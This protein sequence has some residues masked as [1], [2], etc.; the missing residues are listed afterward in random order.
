MKICERNQENAR[1]IRLTKETLVTIEFTVRRSEARTARYHRGRNI[2]PTSAIGNLIFL[3]T[4]KLNIAS[5]LL[6]Y[7]QVVV[8][9]G[10]D[11]RAEAWN[12]SRVSVG[13]DR[14]IRRKEGGGR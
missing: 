12:D 2:N 11:G 5:L 9:S 6:S 14:E 1:A 4:R 10:E 8:S 13:E 7:N 3:P